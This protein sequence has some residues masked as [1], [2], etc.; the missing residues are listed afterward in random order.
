MKYLKKLLFSLKYIILIY[1]IQYVVVIISSAIYLA[2]GYKNLTSFISNKASIILIITYLIFMFVILKKYKY[3]NKSLNKKIY[4][5][6]IY[7]GISIACLLNMLIYLITKTPSKEITTSLYISII[8]TGII[9]PILEEILF[10]YILLNDLKKFNSPKKSIIIATIIFALI[11][12]SPIKIIYAFILGLILNFIYHK[13]DNIK[14]NILVHI[15][16]NIIAIFLIE[17]NIY[18]LILS[19]IGLIISA[20]LLKRIK[21]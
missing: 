17:F 16:A 21:S 7:L 6:L 1:I 14:A 20:I 10:R 12:G 18:I 3:Q 11:H 19:S 9:G 15:S 2:L 4:F 8:S 5:P 13:Y